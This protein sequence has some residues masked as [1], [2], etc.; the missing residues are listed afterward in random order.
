MISEE[1]FKNYEEVPYNDKPKTIKKEK[2]VKEIYEMIEQEN[3]YDI[4][5]T[6][7][8]QDEKLVQ[9][10]LEIYKL[11]FWGVAAL[12]STFLWLYFFLT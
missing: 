11:L 8:L 10:M 9:E 4:F 12:A 6:Y 1:E 5:P 3:I 2:I 7:D